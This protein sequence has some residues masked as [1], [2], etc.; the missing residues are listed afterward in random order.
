MKEKMNALIRFIKKNWVWFTIGGAV[1]LISLIIL[2]VVI[3]SKGTKSANTNLDISDEYVENSTD[4]NNNQ[5]ISKDDE[6]TTAETNEDGEVITT[7]NN[8]GTT[9]GNNST[10]GNGASGNN[11]NGSGNNANSSNNI[12]VGFNTDYAAVGKALTVKIDNAASS[13]SFTYVWTVGGVKSANTTNAYTPTAND[14]EKSI[15]VTVTNVKTAKN[16]EKKVFCSRLPVVYINSSSNITKAYDYVDAS[17]TMQGNATYNKSSNLYSGDITIKL[18][19]NSTKELAKHPYKIKLGSKT[20]IFGFGESKHWVLLANFIDHSFMR[21]KIMYDF[22][23]ALGAAFSAQSENVDLFINGQ[24]AGVYQF[25]EQVRV[26]DSRVDIFDWEGLAEDGAKAIAKKTNMTKAQGDSLEEALTSNLGWISSPYN[27]TYNGTTYKMSD[28]VSIPAKTGG[29]LLEMDFYAKDDASLSR[30]F[31][32]FEQPIYF[33]T[34]EKASTNSELYTYA[35]N[36]IQ[37]FEYALHSPAFTF[38]NGSQQGCTGIT[39][40]W[41]V[42]EWTVNLGTV[43]FSNNELSGKH[44]SQ[45][46]DMNSLVNNFLVCEFSRNWDSMKNSVYMYKDITGLAKLEPAWDFDW[47]FGNTNMYNINT[48]FPTGWQTTDDYFANEQGYQ[49][50]QWNRYLIRDPYF[51]AKVY[52]KYKSV[53]SSVIGGIINSGGKL[54]TAKAYLAEAGVAD[55]GLWGPTYRTYYNNMNFVTASNQ[56][57]TFIT[58][59]V[60]WLDQQ[61]ASYDTLVASLGYYKSSNKLTVSSVEAANG[62]KKITVNVSDSSIKKVCFQVNG[63]AS[64]VIVEVSG[65]KAEYTVSSSELVSGTNV[66]LAYAM[67]SNGEYMKNGNDYITNYKG[68][69]K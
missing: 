56:L 30:I 23:G 37:S 19:G 9:G 48:N 51:L 27:F 68:F 53:R 12:T 62:G 35:K 60:S 26:D 6:D 31:T 41:G 39:K 69:T 58:S 47:A 65:N 5:G 14:L 40:P 16:Y 18:R 10:S 63:A 1:I 49:A 50:T 15:V 43:S 55:F 64:P 44:Y 66:V 2:T 34:P 4:Y 32:N 33:N 38:R 29:F 52:D 13:D 24:Y 25:C 61:F 28:Y 54:D 59:R 67:N 22:S 11:S 17:M 42:L 36:Y 57:K 21:N 46:F 8:N 45:I 3:I 20:D 7:D